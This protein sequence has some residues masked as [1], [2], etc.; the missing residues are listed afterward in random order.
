MCLLV[1]VLLLI[2]CT[3]V[4][5]DTAM[6]WLLLAVLPPLSMLRAVGECASYPSRC[7]TI[8]SLPKPSPAWLNLSGSSSSSR[9]MHLSCECAS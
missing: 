7:R 2:V 3:C 9:I 6:G 5:L 8:S 4:L 1:L